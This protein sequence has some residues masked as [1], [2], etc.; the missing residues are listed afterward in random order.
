MT[1]KDR[2]LDRR[3]AA[4]LVTAE[5]FEVG[6]RALE[7]WAIAGVLMNGR[8]YLRESDV[9]RHAQAMID[10]APATPAPRLRKDR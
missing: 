4:A 2:R 7:K 6:K 1:R 8:V 9:R 5:Y 10:R 3:A